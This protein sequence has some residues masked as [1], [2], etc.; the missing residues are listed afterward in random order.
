MKTLVIIL[1]LFSFSAWGQQ[2]YQVH[3]VEK[4]AQPAGGTAYLNQFIAANIQI[5]I[6][7]AAKGMSAKVFVKGIVETDGS[8]SGLEIVRSVDQFCDSEAIRLLSLYR[9]WKPAMQKGEPVRQLTVFPVSF[10]TDP[11]PEFDSTQHAIIEYFDKNNISASEP[12]KYKF[13][14]VIPVDM[15]GF[16]R[17]DIQYEELRLNQWKLVKKIPFEKKQIRAYVSEEGK[18]DS[19]NAFRLSARNDEYESAYEEV[20]IQPDEK[21]LSHNIYPG[22]GKPP[23]SAKFY[24]LSGMLKQNRAD[25]GAGLII[26]TEW[27]DNGQIYSVSE[28]GGGKGKVIKNVWQKNGG[29]IVIDGNGWGKINGNYYNRSTTF[30]E[31]K[32][33]NGNKSGRWTTKLADSTLIFEEF[34]EDGK[35]IKGIRQDK[36]EYTEQD[37]RPAQFK[38]GPSKMYQFLGNNIQYPYEASRRKISGRVVVSFVVQEDGT[39]TDYQ[40]DRKAGQGLDEE[41]LR[42]VKKSSGLW[43]PGMMRGQKVKIRYTLPIN[44]DV[45]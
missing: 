20:I 7:S 12:Q 27:Y 36:V 32:V 10:R 6:K 41:A 8:M 29:Q 21:I 24:Y 15:R 31:G 44:F 13:R 9:A 34:Y 22:A 1:T 30:E 28:V 35:L 18:P 39:L 33:V 25:D 4:S 5:P 3:E 16:V 19:V 43:E 45:K 26:V 38:G 11:I 2:V 42:V 23:L 17:D 14:N 40:I 37:N